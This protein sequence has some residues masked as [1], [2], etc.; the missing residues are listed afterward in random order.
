MRKTSACSV[1]DSSRG[2]PGLKLDLKRGLHSMHPREPASN[3]EDKEEL[4]QV[5]E[6][7]Q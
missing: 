2:T 5:S 6:K 3:S 1:Q 7:K 4:L